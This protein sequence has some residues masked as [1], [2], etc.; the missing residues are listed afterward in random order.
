MP[1]GAGERADKKMQCRRSARSELFSTPRPSSARQLR[2][3]YRKLD[4]TEEWAENNYYHLPIEQQNARLDPGQRV[5]ARLRQARP[6]SAVPVAQPRRGRRATSPRCCSPWR[7]STCRSRPAS[8]RRKFD[9][10]QMTCTPAARSIAFHEEVQPGRGRRSR[11]RSSSARTS[12]ARRPLP[13]RERRAVRQVRHRRVRRPHRLRLPGRRHQ[14][15]LVAAEARR[16]AADSASARCRSPNG[17][18]TRRRAARPGAVPHADDRLLLL[19]PAAPGKFAHFPV[20]V[21]K[22]ET[23]VAARRAGHVQR[24]RRSRRKIDTESWDYVSQNGT[25]RRGAGVP[26]P[27]ERPPP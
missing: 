26:E 18:A 24:G 6:A 15:D 22:N 21:A 17:Q 20:H 3:L 27:R 10:P 8:T 11:R 4:P 13:R 1:K 7:C 23:L 14:P 9:G 25:R 16:A 12:T 19:L 5:L 2:Q